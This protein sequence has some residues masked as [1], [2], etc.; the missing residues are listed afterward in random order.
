MVG[1]GSRVGTCLL[2]LASTAP[3]QGALSQASGL[4]G[5]WVEEGLSCASIF[6]A[7]RNSIGFRRPASA[8][9]PAFVISGKQL[10]TPLASCRIVD[11]RSSGDRQIISLRC[12]TSIS[13]DA[14]RAVLA[15]TPDGGLY[16]YLAADGSAAAKYQRCRVQDLQSNDGTSTTKQSIVAEAKGVPTEQPASNAP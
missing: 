15:P 12:T 14:A 8:F 10:S 11:V 1:I 3:I 5:A 16:R 2:V 7:A 6:V 9:A 4:Q 13:T